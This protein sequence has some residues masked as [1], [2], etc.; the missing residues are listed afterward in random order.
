MSSAGSHRAFVGLGSNMDEPVAQLRAALLALAAIPQT[1]VVA[2]SSFYRTVPVGYSAQPDFVNA[3]AQVA[4]EHRARNLL[5]RMAA[6][7]R[8][9]GRVRNFRDGPRSLDLD[10]LLYDAE[11]IEEP[12]LTV[13]HPRMHRRAFVLVPLLEIAPDIVVP[14]LG[15]AFDLLRSVDRSG[16]QRLA[17]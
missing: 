4:T 15:S 1:Q 9:Q 12:E 8:A 2:C 6:I 5:E 10:L 7:E 3:V 16:V 17:T 14:G 13:P 11:V